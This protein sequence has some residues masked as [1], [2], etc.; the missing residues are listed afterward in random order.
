MKS[1]V[2]FLVLVT[3]LATGHAMAESS[4]G[5]SVGGVGTFGGSAV[6]P[7]TENGWDSLDDYRAARDCCGYTNSGTDA[8]LWTDAANADG[9][10][11]SQIT[12][13]N[14]VAAT[15]PNLRTS[16]NDDGG[17]CQTLQR[18][19]FLP[20]RDFNQQNPCL[21][22]GYDSYSDYET[23]LTRGFG[24]NQL[25]ITLLDEADT[26]AWDAFCPTPTCSTASRNQ[27]LDAKAAKNLFQTA[28]NDAAT[29]TTDGSLT[30]SQLVA[31]Y[32]DYK[33]EV[34]APYNTA[35]ERD[36]L[37]FY[38]NES[39]HNSPNAMA[40]ATHP[41]GWKAL[42]DAAIGNEAAMAL[43]IIQQIQQT[44]IAKSYLTADLLTTAGVATTYTASSVV[45]QMAAAID[46][47]NLTEASDVANVSSI[48]SWANGLITTAWDAT[49]A[50][51]IA[52]ADSAV[53]SSGSS[54]V[55]SSA[56]AGGG[57]TVA[58][59]LTGE[60]ASGFSVS[61]SGVV[62]TASA[63][64]VGSHTFNVVATPS[65]GDAIS[66]PFTVTVSD[67]T[68]PSFTS[69]GSAGSHSEMVSTST[70]IYT[71]A[72]SDA[73]GDITYAIA[74]D[75][76]SGLTIN[77]ST[78]VVSRNG[79]VGIGDATFTVT[80]TDGAGNVSAPKSVTVTFTMA[81]LASWKAI[82]VGSVSKS[83][84]NC[85]SRCAGEGDGWTCF[86]YNRGRGD[87]TGGNWPGNMPS[88]SSHWHMM[89]DMD[90]TNGEYRAVFVWW[91]DDYRTYECGPDS[92]CGGNTRWMICGRY[93][94]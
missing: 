91:D 66:R 26:D 92:G 33:V 31:N 85:Q 64:A 21:S 27:F 16:C 4:D 35:P 80:A 79:S 51:A 76:A 37:M 11:T 47:S 68:A 52:K 20:M 34:A 9:G 1:L 86:R 19:T 12:N 75:G 24:L 61:S 18:D 36:W 67:T 56:T 23:A 48:E 84:A 7:V 62:T 38:L 83:E 6:N 70:T 8:Q 57:G 94:E 73:G 82:D 50:S 49:P 88:S 72:A 43:W 28:L 65:I 58:Y 32:G 10:S 59:S 40:A 78:G 14:C 44:T 69:G 2:R 89:D 45:T 46:D 63:L 74:G 30:W 22:P 54:I 93:T 42:V 53:S 39:D 81:T 25:D 60:G 13:A 5:F 41:N 15:Y 55:T 17:A 87:N 71:A 90:P 29:T 77:A 3:V